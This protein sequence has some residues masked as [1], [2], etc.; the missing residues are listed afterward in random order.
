MGAKFQRNNPRN[1]RPVPPM[2]SFDSPDF[3]L[4]MEEKFN[5]V[6]EK[7]DNLKENVDG[8]KD[9][10]AGVDLGVKELAHIVETMRVTESQHYGACPN[11]SELK[12]LSAQVQEF[13]FF[14]KHKNTFAISYGVMFLGLILTLYEGSSKYHDVILKLKQQ[15]IEQSAIKDDVQ[16]NTSGRLKTDAKVSANKS[17]FYRSQNKK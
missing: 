10:I 5:L 9:N 17:E 1:Y 16:D 11:T 2:P 13:T 6:H 8:L 14:K 3:R 12:T 7:V 15:S 4:Y